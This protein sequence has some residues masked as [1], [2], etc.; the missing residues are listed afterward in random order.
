MLWMVE[1]SPFNRYELLVK[2]VRIKRFDMRT[3]IIKYPH[4][5]PFASARTC[6]DFLRAVAVHVGQ[7]HRSACAS[8]FVIRKKSRT[9]QCPVHAYDAHVRPPAWAC[10]EYDFG[11][12]IAIDIARSHA[13]ITSPAVIIGIHRPLRHSIAGKS[14]GSLA[15]AYRVKH[16]R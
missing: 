6:Q 7:S 5:R 12:T 8:L 14:K 9:F 1:G 4:L 3:A 2:I 13:H 11:D 15:P 16:A 10:C